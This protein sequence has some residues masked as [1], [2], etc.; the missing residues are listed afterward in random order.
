MRVFRLLSLAKL[1]YTEDKL[2]S[3]SV[4]ALA[5]LSSTESYSDLILSQYSADVELILKST[6]G[7]DLITNWETQVQSLFISGSFA[8]SCAFVNEICESI[9]W[10][11]LSIT[12]P[13]EKKQIKGNYAKFS[14]NDDTFN[15]QCM[16]LISSLLQ[17]S[18]SFRVYF[19][20][21]HFLTLIQINMDESSQC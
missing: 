7:S 3:E 16:K 18:S 21:Y 17:N 5:N 4:R 19:N 12:D 2:V 1:S 8:W 9:Y 14:R 20:Y 15:I 11:L 6:A 10:F 13:Q